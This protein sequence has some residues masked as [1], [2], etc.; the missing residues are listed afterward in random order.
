MGQVLHGPLPAI[1][2]P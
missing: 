2:N 1:T